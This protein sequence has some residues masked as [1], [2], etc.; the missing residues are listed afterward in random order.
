MPSSRLLASCNPLSMLTLPFQS[1]HA[2]SAVTSSFYLTC[3]SSSHLSKRYF[4]PRPGSLDTSPLKWV[5]TAPPHSGITSLD[6]YRYTTPL[7]AAPP[8]W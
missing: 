8:P 3:V 1:R 5:C 7:T 2:R 6:V 4:S